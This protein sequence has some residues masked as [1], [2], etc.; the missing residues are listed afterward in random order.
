M[1]P[2]GRKD[3]VKDCKEKF[4]TIVARESRHCFL[5]CI[6]INYRFLLGQAW[7]YAFCG[8]YDSKLLEDFAVRCGGVRCHLNQTPSTVSSNS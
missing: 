6:I 5:T 4:F 7:Q 2:L 3:N 8:R 1:L